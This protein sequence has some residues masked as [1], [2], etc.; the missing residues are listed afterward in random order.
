MQ[1]IKDYVRKAMDKFRADDELREKTI[2][3]AVTVAVMI[4][5]LIFIFTGKRPVKAPER[6]FSGTDSYAEVLDTSDA[7]IPPVVQD[8]SQISFTYSGSVNVSTETNQ[9]SLLFQNPSQSTRDIVLQVVL[10]DKGRDVII[11]QSDKL[12]A[13]YMLQNMELLRSDGLPAGEYSG[14][15]RIHFYGTDTGERMTGETSI[16]VTITVD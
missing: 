16:P 2:L 13:G 14:C 11:A 6:V 12:P 3:V 5:V 15:F 10:N 7:D 9:L 1:N 8:E 4:P